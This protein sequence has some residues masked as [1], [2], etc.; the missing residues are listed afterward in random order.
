MT[1]TESKVIE[2][3]TGLQKSFLACPIDKDSE[4]YKDVVIRVDDNE[5]EIS[6][7]DAAKVFEIS[8]LFLGALLWGFDGLAEK[9]VS[10]LR[11]CWMRMDELEKRINQLEE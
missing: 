10:D 5:K 6:I 8:P 9:I 2:T 11:S 3:S 4:D 1:I 7:E